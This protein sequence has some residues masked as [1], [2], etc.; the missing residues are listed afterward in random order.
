MSKINGQKVI[1]ASMHNGIFIPGIGEIKKEVSTTST[2][3][4]VKSLTI[5]EPFLILEVL[6]DKSRRIYTVPVPLT[7]FAS[8]VLESTPITTPPLK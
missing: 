8:L 5:D 4:K 7:N 3:S 1:M 2:G 6:E